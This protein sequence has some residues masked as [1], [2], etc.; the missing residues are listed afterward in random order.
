MKSKSIIKDNLIIFSDNMKELR[1]K[2]TQAKLAT[3]TNISED[4]IKRIEQGSTS[5]TLD[6]LQQLAK[7]YLNQNTNISLPYFLGLSK[8]N[9]NVYNPNDTISLNTKSLNNI[10]E[11]KQTGLE[12]LFNLIISQPEFMQLIKS[13]NN[14]SYYINDSS[15]DIENYPK[16]TQNN[17]D[18]ISLQN[19]LEN[20]FKTFTTTFIKDWSSSTFKSKGKKLLISNNKRIIPIN[21]KK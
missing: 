10:K 6:T 12:D 13:I 20:L 11:I 4:T 2:T 7:F 18:L 8:S 3:K 15:A 16:I 19:N 14:I 1:G 17:A 21:M 5:P 9:T